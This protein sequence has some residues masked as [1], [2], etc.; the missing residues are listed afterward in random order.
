MGLDRVTIAG[1][2]FIQAEASRHLSRCGRLVTRC[3]A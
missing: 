1:S 2:S 3:C